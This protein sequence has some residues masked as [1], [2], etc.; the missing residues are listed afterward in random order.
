MT[1]GV[2]SFRRGKNALVQRVARGWLVALRFA[3]A[4][5]PSH[6]SRR[7]IPA[8][9]S[10]VK[11]GALSFFLFIYTNADFC[12]DP[13]TDECAGLLARQR[14]SDGAVRLVCGA[15]SFPAVLSDLPLLR[16]NQSARVL[17][18]VK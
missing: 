11:R 18:A 15:E 16:K 2:A 4:A 3:H 5:L 6:V 7:T 1:A 10:C 12:C 17:C 8:A 14:S 9:A 13:T